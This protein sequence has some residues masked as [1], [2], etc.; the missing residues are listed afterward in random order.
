[1]DHVS[2]W[3]QKSTITSHKYRYSMQ[4]DGMKGVLSTAWIADSWY[5]YF[6]PS[7]IVSKLNQEEKAILG[8]CILSNFM[9]YTVEVEH[10][11]VN[12]IVNK[13]SLGESI[14]F[15]GKQERMTCYGVFADEVYHAMFSYDLLSSLMYSGDIHK[16]HDFELDSKE[17]SKKI[18]SLRRCDNDRDTEVSMLALG[19]YSEVCIATQLTNIQK[20]TIYEPVYN[21]LKDHL[22][23]EKRHA[24][25]FVDLMRTFWKTS[26]IADKTLFISK[27]FAVMELNVSYMDRT[28]VK[29]YLSYIDKADLFSLMPTIKPENKF[30]G[31]ASFVERT[32]KVLFAELNRLGAWDVQEL[33]ELLTRYRLAKFA[34]GGNLCVEQRY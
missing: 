17:K 3:M 1:M 30:E 33:N 11:I 10:G 23:D 25:I 32:S 21:A 4:V 16:I 6:L 7:V 24:A 15:S 28:W 2:N 27:L 9:S 12:P 19:V 5:S 13:I 8:A 18:V 26:T 29:N 20:D 14:F 31:V 34:Q 22:D